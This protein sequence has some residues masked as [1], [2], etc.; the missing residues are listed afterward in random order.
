MSVN[1]KLKYFIINR[2]LKYLTGHL[3]VYTL[4]AF[5]SLH[6]CFINIETFNFK[7]FLHLFHSITCKYIWCRSFACNGYN[8][9]HC[10]LERGS[11]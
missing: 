7:S 2:K 9:R 10:L 11:F 1:R 3:T 4:T 6:N 5:L 8:C